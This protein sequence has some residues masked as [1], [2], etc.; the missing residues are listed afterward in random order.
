MVLTAQLVRYAMRTPTRM[1]TVPEMTQLIRSRVHAKRD[2]TVTGCSVSHV[3]NV[4]HKP[5]LLETV[6]LGVL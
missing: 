5:C 2:F 6:M 1:A 4:I 3:N